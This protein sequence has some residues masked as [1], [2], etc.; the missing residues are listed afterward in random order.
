M[1]V[2]IYIFCFVVACLCEH[3]GL[4]FVSFL[5]LV[6]ERVYSTPIQECVQITL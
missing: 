1:F 5:A 4:T 6:Q 3:N 2:Y